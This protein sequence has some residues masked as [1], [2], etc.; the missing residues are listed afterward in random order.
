MK[1]ATFDTEQ[2]YADVRTL[3]GSEL[4]YLNGRLLEFFFL[5]EIVLLLLNAENILVKT[6]IK[7]LH[8]VSRSFWSWDN[9]RG[10]VRQRRQH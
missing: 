5:L 7:F 4:N 1:L 10:D 8:F 6:E 2:E 3:I 9:H